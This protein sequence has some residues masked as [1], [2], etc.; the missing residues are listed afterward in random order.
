M[1]A[2]W[3]QEAAKEKEQKKLDREA[4]K[5]ERLAQAPAKQAAKEAKAR[6][7]RLAQQATTVSKKPKRGPSTAGPPLVHVVWEAAEKMPGP[8][9]VLSPL[10]VSI[11]P[12]PE[13]AP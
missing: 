5:A 4:R 9:P 6:E 11:A 10:P 12:M 3:P 8:E 1:L 13:H 2:P 7:R